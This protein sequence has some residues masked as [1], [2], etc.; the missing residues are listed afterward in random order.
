VQSPFSYAAGIAEAGLLCSRAARFPQQ[1]LR[2]DK[3]RLVFLKPDGSTHAEATDT[4]VRRA[5][6]PG[7]ELPAVV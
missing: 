1:E 3:S 7:F 4:C 6:R 5:Y 2:W